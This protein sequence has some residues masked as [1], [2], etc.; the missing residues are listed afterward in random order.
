MA[1]AQERAT[2]EEPLD[3]A[4]NNGFTIDDG[5]PSIELLRV[6]RAGDRAALNE[7]FGDHWRRLRRWAHGKLPRSARSMAETVDL[8]QDVMVNAFRRLDAIEV[9]RRGALQAYLRQSIHNRIRD[10]LRSVGRRAPH[11][12][13]DSQAPGHAPSPLDLAID[14]QARERY[15]RGLS[16]LSP[17]DQELI[18]GRLELG[19]S[20]EQL[21]SVTGR[22]GP[23]AVRIA[24]RRAVLK[25]AAEMSRE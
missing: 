9:R 1:Y 2:A 11:G 7:L 6:A 16:R 18:V 12:P 4:S 8:V 21:A 10:E 25:L 14:A 23:E 3:D 13:L 20:Y 15:T 19:Y 5:V 22:C 24:V 17:T